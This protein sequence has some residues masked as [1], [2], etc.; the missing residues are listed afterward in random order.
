LPGLPALIRCTCATE[1]Q[2]SSHQ[3][4]EIGRTMRGPIRPTQTKQS[5]SRLAQQLL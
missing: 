4:P 1:T 3:T 2:I 5:V